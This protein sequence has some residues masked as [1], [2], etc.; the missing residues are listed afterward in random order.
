MVELDRLD[1]PIYGKYAS[2]FVIF[3]SW[4]FWDAGRGDLFPLF[5]PTQNLKMKA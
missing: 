3:H 4:H 2:S 5:S 1:L